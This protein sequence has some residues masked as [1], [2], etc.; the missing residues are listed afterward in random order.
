MYNYDIYS[1]KYSYKK[2]IE[3]DKKERGILFNKKEICIEK[4]A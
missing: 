2:L 4:M 1:K 3:I